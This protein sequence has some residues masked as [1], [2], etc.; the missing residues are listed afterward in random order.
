MKSS[1]DG[2]ES[3]EKEKTSGV[4]SLVK[5]DSLDESILSNMMNSSIRAT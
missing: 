3:N 2:S 4:V 5:I 1:L